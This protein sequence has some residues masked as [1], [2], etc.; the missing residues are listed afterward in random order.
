MRALLAAPATSLTPA[1]LSLAATLRAVVVSVV[2]L[3][4]LLSL[5]TLRS[6]A[7]RLASG[8]AGL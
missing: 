2:S 1:F 3:V 5:I 6:P 8:A 7:V 4:A